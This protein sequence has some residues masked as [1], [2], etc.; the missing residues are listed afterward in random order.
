MCYSP[1]TFPGFVANACC[2]PC[3]ENSVTAQRVDS[4]TDNAAGGCCICCCCNCGGNNS[5]V[6]GIQSCGCG[7]SAVGG[8]QNCGCGCRG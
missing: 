3:C 1:L 5:A 6:G 2:N 7:N 4:A 8:I